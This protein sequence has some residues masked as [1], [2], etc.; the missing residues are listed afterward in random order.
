MNRI[1]WREDIPMMEKFVAMAL[2]DAADDEGVA[3][4]AVATIALKCSCSERAVQKSVKALCGKGLLRRRERKDRSSFYIFVLENLPQIER[5]RRRKERGPHA[6]LT[7]EPDSPDLFGTGERRSPTGESHSLTGE[8][9]SLTGERGAPRT[10]NEPSIEPSIEILGDFTSPALLIDEVESS[11]KPDAPSDD[12]PELTLTEHIE[13]RWRDLKAQHPGIAAVRK[14]DDGLKHQIELR[15]KQHATDGQTA[16]DVWNEAIDA[17]GRSDF[18]TGR[19]PPGRGRDVPFKLTL[20]WLSKATNFREVIGGKYERTRDPA[21][22]DPDT[23][24]RLGPTE[25][26]LAVSVARFRAGQERRFGS[27]NSGSDLPRLTG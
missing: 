25:Q 9:H 4:P 27:G 21:L 14:I 5:E 19:V 16:I 8:R 17:V 13:T 11:D 1:W 2:A 18:L 23:G 6:D 3:Y 12:S 22:C 24:R 15:A 20:A 26:A 7:G 10:I